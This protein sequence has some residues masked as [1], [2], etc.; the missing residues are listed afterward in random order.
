MPRRDNAVEPAGFLDRAPAAKQ[1]NCCGIGVGVRHWHIVLRAMSITL[2]IIITS[3]RL[4]E[5]VMQEVLAD[6]L[7]AYVGKPTT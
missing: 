7:V 4:K 6:V 5:S 3:G 2:P 1:R